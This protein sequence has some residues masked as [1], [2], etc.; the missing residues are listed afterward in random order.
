MQLPRAGPLDRQRARVE[1][2]VGIRGRE[3]LAIAQP[4]AA[5]AHVGDGNARG[6]GERPEQRVVGTPADRID[7]DLQN[8][9]AGQGD[10]RGLLALR[11]G[12]ARSA[13]SFV[14]DPRDCVKRHA[15]AKRLDEG[16]VQFPGA[17]LVGIAEHGQ[18]HRVA[19]PGPGRC[20]RGRPDLKS[21]TI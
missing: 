5:L 2:T 3:P 13:L 11:A 1:K 12:G 14:A 21:V 10:D 7:A 6:F 4:L 16:R 19:A 20:S 15:L 8:V 17:V 9:V 18:H